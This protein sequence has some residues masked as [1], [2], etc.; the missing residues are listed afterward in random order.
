M[1]YRQVI[2]TVWAVVLAVVIVPTAQAD[3]DTPQL[4]IERVTVVPEAGALLIHGSNLCWKPRI[5]LAGQRL[6][7]IGS[8]TDIVAMMPL[9]IEPGDY[10]L[11][12]RCR[13][14]SS[15]HDVWQLT[16]GSVGPAGPT[17]PP[18]PAGPRGPAGPPGPMGVSG[19]PG[20][21]GPQGP[22]GIVDFYVTASPM[23]TI[24][25]QAIEVVTVNCQPGDAAVSWST[26]GT[27]LLVLDPPLELPGVRGDLNVKPLTT[28]TRPTG[29]QFTY[30]C[31]LTPSCHLTFRVIC[32]ALRPAA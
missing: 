24:A 13:P 25:N 1:V 16:V 21:V 2:A 30:I 17:G 23:R 29:F 15:G 19:P 28:G 22:P 14:G 3:A 4:V 12:V 31:Q 6:A 9:G 11:E 26:E 7:A 18:G 27:G 10:L 32:A 5:R 8:A 20:P